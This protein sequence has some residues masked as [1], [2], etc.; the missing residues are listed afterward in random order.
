[1]I[2]LLLAALG[3]TTVALSVAQLITAWYGRRSFIGSDRGHGSKTY[4]GSVILCS[5]RS[6]A[7][8]QTDSRFLLT[9][10]WEDVTRPGVFTTTHYARKEKLTYDV[11]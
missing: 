10:G 6:R 2:A 4:Q 9:P 11:R 1:M 3:I 8:R 5:G 7:N